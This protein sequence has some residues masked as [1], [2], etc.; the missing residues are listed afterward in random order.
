MAD[1]SWCALGARVW[2]MKQDGTLFINAARVPRIFEDQGVTRRHHV[3]LEWD[4]SQMSADQI[5][6]TERGEQLVEEV[7]ED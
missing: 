3:R 5:L 6:V 7:L 4:G 2:K 1:D